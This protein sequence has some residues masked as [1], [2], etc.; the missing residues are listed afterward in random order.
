MKSQ[1]GNV[2]FLILIAVVLF[3][4]LSYAVSLTMRGTGGNATQ[5]SAQVSAARLLNYAGSLQAGVMRLMT[6]NGVGITDLNFSND[7]WKNSNGTPVMGAMGNPQNPKL[8]VFHPGGGNLAAQTF[9]DISSC[10]CGDPLPGHS[11]LSWVNVE[12]NGTNTADPMLFIYSITDDVCQALNKQL[13]IVYSGTRPLLD[14]NSQGFLGT[15]AP[16]SI[17]QPSGSAASK[18]AIKGRSAFCFNSTDSNR[19][20]FAY[21]LQIN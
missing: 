20:I 17:S 5:E 13:G 6:I 1:N 15:T 16:P 18:A 4:A 14:L 7:I 3:A 2:L 10:P 11:R 21:S 8:Y 19:N 9:A 12:G